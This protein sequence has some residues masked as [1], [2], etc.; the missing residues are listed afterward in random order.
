MHAPKCEWQQV[1]SELGE[2]RHILNCENSKAVK[3]IGSGDR[4][5]EV[6]RV[7]NEVGI[8]NDNDGARFGV[9]H[10]GREWISIR[11]PHEK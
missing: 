2:T 1:F 4:G 10:C 6:L 11:Q 7:R 3:A 9:L 8:V 5:A